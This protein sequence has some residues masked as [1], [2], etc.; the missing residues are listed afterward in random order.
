MS[1]NSITLT[2]NLAFSEEWCDISDTKA[3]LPVELKTP[4]CPENKGF[5]SWITRFINYFSDT[6]G[7]KLTCTQLNDSLNSVFSQKNEWEA[8]L[9][10]EYGGTLQVG[11]RSKQKGG[12]TYVVSAPSH[13]L[14]DK[15]S[16][17]AM[18]SGGRSAATSLG[19]I[20]S[21]YSQGQV[22]AFVPIAQSNTCGYFGS[23]G[24][25]VLLEVSINDGKIE[26]AKLHDSKNGFIDTFYDGAAH[27][28]K[29][30]LSH[31]NLHL[32]ENFS[33]TVEHHGDQAL[34]NGSDCGRYVTYYASTL[35][36]EGNLSGVNSLSTREFFK[37]YF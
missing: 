31:K 24:H 35:I 2:P 10:F 20:Q 29:Q 1:I 5:S 36:D 4:P 25:F 34:L 3:S 9:P 37:K 26:S 13:D 30:L 19:E 33:V 11:C 14:M 27:L 28:T 8:N 32:D 17:Q 22:K 16:I 15:N 12:V 23:R 18:L 21:H 6:F 7:D